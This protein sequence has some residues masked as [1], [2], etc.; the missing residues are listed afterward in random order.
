MGY[1]FIVALA[2]DQ[3][4]RINHDG[5]WSV[6]WDKAEAISDKT[7]VSE[8]NSAT[9]AIATAL[10]AAK[11][12]LT[13]T[14]W[15]VSDSQADQWT[16]PGKIIDIDDDDDLDTYSFKL[17]S[18]DSSVARVTTEAEWMVEWT[19]VRVISKEKRNSW[20]RLAL[21]SFC[22]MLMAAK[23]DLHTIDWE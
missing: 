6:D 17:R 13:L 10:M 4:A 16:H 8:S 20:R 21:V 23:D 19:D 1:P 22:R 3:F 7:K 11:D 2:G 18:D 12:K 15:A 14:P 5:I 9:V